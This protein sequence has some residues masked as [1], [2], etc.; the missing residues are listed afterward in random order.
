MPQGRDG[1]GRSAAARMPSL[2]SFFV[3]YG[4]T[5]HVQVHVPGMEKDP[6][7]RS[8]MSSTFLGSTRP[9]R[10]ITSCASEN[11]PG[12]G[13]PPLHIGMENLCH[14]SARSLRPIIIMRYCKKMICPCSPEQEI[15]ILPAPTR[16][17]R[18]SPSL[19]RDRWQ[20]LFTVGT[21]IPR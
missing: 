15:Q 7:F 5:V 11:V 13:I 9:M 16:E 10:S 19:G 14:S 20:T 21:H 1:S 12:P 6:N 8:E 18:D 3:T 17:N 2:P 4:G